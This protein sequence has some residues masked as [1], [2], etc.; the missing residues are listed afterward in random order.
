[1][2]VLVLG[3]IHWQ[4]K[5]KNGKEQII[6]AFDLWNKF[7][8]INQL[9]G[10]HCLPDSLFKFTFL[11]GTT[12]WGKAGSRLQLPRHESLRSS[13]CSFA[14]WIWLCPLA[15][16]S[17]CSNY[18][19]AV[20]IHRSVRAVSLWG[21][22]AEH[23]SRIWSAGSELG[24]TVRRPR[25]EFSAAVW[26]PGAE[27]IPVWCPAAELC[28]AVRSACTVH[29]AVRRTHRSEFVVIWR[30][31]TKFFN[32]FWRASAKF[33]LSFWG[34]CAR[35]FVIRCAGSERPFAVWICP[36]AATAA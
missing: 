20:R 27:H 9:N 35:D 3:V 36:S 6:C 10:N 15:I 4:G 12:W 22:C 16:R 11:R 24:L 14:T 7:R 19:L 31:S 28:I 13:A 2:F 30:T 25:A 32:A 18:G 5:P 34:P 23:R 33:V 21:A 1:M 29:F 26:G 17:A 8:N